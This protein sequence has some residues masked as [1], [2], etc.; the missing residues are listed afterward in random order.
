[1]CSNPSP[2]PRLHVHPPGCPMM[3]GDPCRGP[4]D[5]RPPDIF[6]GAHASPIQNSR[7]Y[8]SDMGRPNLSTNTLLS[9]K[10]LSMKLTRKR[11]HRRRKPKEYPTGATAIRNF[12]L[13]CCGYR[14]DEVR[15]CTDPE[16]WLFPWRF[17]KRPTA[18]DRDIGNVHDVPN[19]ASQTLRVRKIPDLRG[20]RKAGLDAWGAEGHGSSENAS[21]A[22]KLAPAQDWKPQKTGAGLC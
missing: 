15:L 2:R 8:S 9:A 4:P 3:S 1:M 12:C 18:P 17:G 22:S 19:R 20:A 5:H 21:Q 6:A 7:Y 11:V 14:A 10:G 13:E 16:C